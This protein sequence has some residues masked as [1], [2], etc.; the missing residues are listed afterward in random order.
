MTEQDTQFLE[1]IVKALV[2]NPDAVKTSRRV[3]DMGV[4]IELVVDPADMGRL[5]VPTSIAKMTESQRRIKSLSRVALSLS[6]LNRRGEVG[7]Q[8]WEEALEYAFWPMQKL[9]KDLGSTI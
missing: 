8:E 7:S 1:Y 5:M 6:C 9:C 2:E 4:F 3:D